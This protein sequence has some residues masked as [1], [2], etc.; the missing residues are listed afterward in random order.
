MKKISLMIV[1]DS[2]LIRRQISRCSNADKFDIVAE[3]ADGEHAVQQFSELR[4]QVVTMDLTM[5]KVDGITCI[6]RIILMEPTVQILV[7]SALSSPET[8]VLALQRGAT[9]F[10][11]K[12]F[13]EEQLIDALETVA[14][15]VKDG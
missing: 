7:I 9:G 5:P 6:D 13:T 3:A 4:P 8:G 11:N 15:G 14:T 12:P 1:D 2:M 10:I